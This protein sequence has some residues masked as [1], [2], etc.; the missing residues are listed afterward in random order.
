MSV[1]RHPLISCTGHVGKSYCC[2]GEHTMY[3]SVLPYRGSSPSASTTNYTANNYPQLTRITCTSPSQG[4][5]TLSLFLCLLAVPGL[6]L[7]CV[8]VC[9]ALPRRR[10]RSPASR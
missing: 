5:S 8:C 3:S 2:V 9:G 7:A 10:A 6:G 4:S 1:L